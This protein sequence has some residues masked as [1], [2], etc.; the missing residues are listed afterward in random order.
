MRRK[1]IVAHYAG[2]I[3]LGN[4]A[5]TV[6]RMMIDNHNLGAGKQRLQRAAQP[7]LVV[8]RM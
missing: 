3:P 1:T 8:M 5:S 7:Q 6:G 2:A 4:A